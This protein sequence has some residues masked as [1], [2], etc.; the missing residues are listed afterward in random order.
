MFPWT[1]RIS[2]VVLFFGISATTAST[3]G[4]VDQPLTIVLRVGEQ[5]SL[6]ANGVKSYSEGAPGIADIRVTRDQS[7]FVIVGTSVGSGSL[8]LIRHD[9]T[10]VQ[11]TISVI[12]GRAVF[13][14]AYE[15]ALTA[16][17]AHVK[18]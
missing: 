18:R 1:K 2:L 11:Y 5:K 17:I 10:Q 7:R 16:V 4:D 8:L 3:R 13:H 14:C 12:P 9:G 15:P 6:S